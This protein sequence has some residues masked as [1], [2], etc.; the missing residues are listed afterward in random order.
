MEERTSDPE[1]TSA[2]GEL[3]RVGQVA[4]ERPA[5]PKGARLRRVAESPSG[6][7]TLMNSETPAEV[8][9]VAEEAPAV[10]VAA[11]RV[12]GAVTIRE[13]EMMRKMEDIERL[14]EIRVGGTTNIE[15]EVIGAI[16]GVAAQSVQGVSSLGA[17]SLRSAIRERL[18]GA[19]RMGRGVQVE[20]GLREVILD[21]NVRVVYGYSIPRVVVEV[22]RTVA[23]GLLRLCGLVS[24]EINVRITSIEFPDRMPGRVE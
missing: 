14:E 7:A 22:R 1:N 20:A 16:A 2:L 24:K 3:A 9:V 17:T 6:D 13:L 11:G 10:D 15:A 12:M 4:D 21:I 23:D 5:P 8:E 18:G 19:E